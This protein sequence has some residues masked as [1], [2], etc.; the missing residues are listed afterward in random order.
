VQSAARDTPH[1]PAVARGRAFA[2]PNATVVA[3]NYPTAALPTHMFWDVAGGASVASMGG[4]A[5][6]GRR[7]R[8]ELWEL[9]RP[10]RRLI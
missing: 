3:T 6:A 2:A 10:G 7:L 9:G 4:A 1:L 5:A 8:P